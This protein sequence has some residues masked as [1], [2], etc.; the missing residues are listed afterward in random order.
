M[1]VRPNSCLKT[2]PLYKPQ[3]DPGV[4]FHY[5]CSSYNIPEALLPSPPSFLHY[6][7]SALKA[8]GIAQKHQ[9]S[10]CKRKSEACCGNSF[11]PG[12]IEASPTTPG[13]A[14]GRSCSQSWEQHPITCPVSHSNTR[15]GVKLGVTGHQGHDI[16]DK[17]TPIFTC[18]PTYKAASLPLQWPLLRRARKQADL[19]FASKYI[20]FSAS[21]R[22][23]QQENHKQP[24][25]AQG[26]F[27][28]TYLPTLILKPF[29]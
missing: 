26:A 4:L 15:A 6:N 16:Q 24:D 8:S 13:A 10:L 2:P 5:L 29:S 1:L 19:Q 28:Q 23:E 27:A 18:K 11:V 20:P 21:A 7:L 3:Q 17:V 9:K 12:Q 14:C 22:E 25:I